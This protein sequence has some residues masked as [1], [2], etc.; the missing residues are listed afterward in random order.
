MFDGGERGRGE[1]S[2]ELL[3]EGKGAGERGGAGGAALWRQE[4]GVGVVHGRGTARGG[5]RRARR[6]RVGG[7]RREERDT[8]PFSFF[9]FLIFPAAAVLEFFL[10][11]NQLEIL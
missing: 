8:C 6:A 1:R 7:R 5:E 9:N 10:V 4:R 2:P 3:A 11:S